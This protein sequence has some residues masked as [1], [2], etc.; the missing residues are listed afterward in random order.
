MTKAKFELSAEKAQKR[1]ESNKQ[2]TL[3]MAGEQVDNVR[4]GNISYTDADGVPFTFGEGG[5]PKAL[6]NL[7]LMDEYNNQQ[8]REHIANGD[9]GL[10]T[11]CT[12]VASVSPEQARELTPFMSQVDVILDTYENADGIK[13]LSVARIS[14]P[15]AGLKVKTKSF[16]DAFGEVVGTKT[17]IKEEA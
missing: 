5:E 1:L 12:L 16:A 11:N 4:V 7:Q 13:C 10:A 9:F 17:P 15:K 2:V 14:G 6:V 3:S 8:A